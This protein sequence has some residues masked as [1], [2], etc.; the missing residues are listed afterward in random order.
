MAHVLVDGH[1]V[2]HAWP[3]LASLLRS[4]EWLA[5]EALVDVLERYQDASGEVVTV[6]FDAPR[7]AQGRAN[8]TGFRGNVEVLYAPKPGGADAVIERFI[9][10]AKDASE[11]TVVS[12]DRAVLQYAF[13]KGA[14]TL[15]AQEFRKQCPS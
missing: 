10:N 15:S 1:N 11:V 9:F 14:R 5:R 12:R 8:E 7:G 2:I 6:V 4:S 13:G 3:D